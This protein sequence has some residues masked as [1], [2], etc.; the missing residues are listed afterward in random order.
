M[1]NTKQD[2]IYQI[3][4]KLYANLIELSKYEKL[5]AKD[6]HREIKRK[7]DALAEAKEKFRGFKIDI[8]KKRRELHYQLRKESIRKMIGQPEV[9]DTIENK[10]NKVQCKKCG[11]TTVTI[12]PT[13]MFSGAIVNETRCS[14]CKTIISVDEI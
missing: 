12:T 4:T 3:K 11:C 6:Y 8:S 5:N 10:E 9:V 1:N 2:E 14:L 7:T 13:R